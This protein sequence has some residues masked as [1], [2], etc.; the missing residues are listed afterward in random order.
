MMKQHWSKVWLDLKVVRPKESL[1]VVALKQTQT[2]SSGPATASS[3]F[4]GQLGSVT[5]TSHRNRIHKTDSVSKL[6]LELLRSENRF[7]SVTVLVPKPKLQ[8]AIVKAELHAVLDVQRCA[9]SGFVGAIWY[10]CELVVEFLTCAQRDWAFRTIS[11]ASSTVVKGNVH[12]IGSGGAGEPKLY[13]SWVLPFYRED[14]P[15]TLSS[16]L[17]NHFVGTGYSSFFTFGQFDRPEG[18]I[19]IIFHN[20]PPAL[21][22][23]LKSHCFEER[24]FW[25]ETVTDSDYPLQKEQ[26]RNG[27]SSYLPSVV[28]KE[29]KANADIGVAEE[30]ANDTG[31]E[32]LGLAV[33][34]SDE[35]PACPL[36]TEQALKGS[37]STVPPATQ[38]TT[39][40]NADLDAAE[41]PAS[42]DDNRAEASPAEDS[43]I[44]TEVN[45]NVDAEEDQARDT[46]KRAEASP[47]KDS[48]IETLTTSHF[49]DGTS[50]D[51]N[52]I[53]EGQTQS[54][55]KKQSPEK[56]QSP[57]EEAENDCPADSE[58]TTTV[59]VDDTFYKIPT[60][61]ALSLHEATFDTFTRMYLEFRHEKSEKTNCKTLIKLYR[62]FLETQFPYVDCG[63]KIDAFQRVSR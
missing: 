51:N 62:T 40:V 27:S 37:E 63:R 8:A 2:L 25:T 16:A 12:P 41:Q 14:T 54:P 6:Q 53:S 24:W 5:S 43:G 23:I 45:A 46:D 31:K 3:R 26:R 59:L 20:A 36:Q 34:I 39:K 32:S 10:W 35:E 60:A 38:G 55:E 30:V 48:V 50:G 33:K 49:E 21:K 17:D 15:A 1:G 56:E 11:R 44:E 9:D 58:A 29:V 28:Q 18:H 22:T 61:S 42:D 7:L 13:M 19:R 52:D 57:E 47:A 4:P